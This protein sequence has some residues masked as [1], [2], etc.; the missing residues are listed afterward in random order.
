MIDKEKIK[1]VVDK[2]TDIVSDNFQVCDEYASSCT[3]LDWKKLEKEITIYL[4]SLLNEPNI[5]TYLEFHYDPRLCAYLHHPKSK[6]NWCYC[7]EKK[8]E[9]EK[10]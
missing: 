9:R 8:Y 4:E 5:E 7:G 1:E 6:S 3:A 2:I 10:N